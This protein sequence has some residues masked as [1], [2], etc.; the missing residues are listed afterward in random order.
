MS[1]FVVDC[2]VAVKWFVP[3][4][5]AESAGRLLDERFELHAPDLLFPEFGNNLVKK[6]RRGELTIEEIRSIVS[7]LWTVP[8]EIHS[9][10]TLLDGAIELATR[11]GHTV[12][13]SL[14]VALALLLDCPAVT[15]DEQLVRALTESNLSQSIQHIARL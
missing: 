11:T 10:Q 8:L 2:S 13:D 3:E 9:S 12:Y 4:R 7:A 15:A 14:Y 6:H 5:Y 1:V